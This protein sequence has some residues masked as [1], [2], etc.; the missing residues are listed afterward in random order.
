M[1]APHCL[2]CRGDVDG[3]ILGDC[4]ASDADNAAFSDFYSPPLYCVTKPGHCP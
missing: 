4:K 3:G 1:Y 2:G